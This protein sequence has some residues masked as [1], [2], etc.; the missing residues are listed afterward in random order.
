MVEVH[1]SGCLACVDLRSAK[2][3][4]LWM[5]H[6]KQWLEEYYGHE[7]E[8]I[9]NTLPVTTSNPELYIKDLSRMVG[10][11]DERTFFIGE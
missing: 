7:V 8:V 10:E 6:L 1:L 5:N 9:G 2:Y 4:F 3:P 11:P